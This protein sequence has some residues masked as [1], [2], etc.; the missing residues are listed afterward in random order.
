MSSLQA[1]YVS[2]ASPA[3]L[4]PALRKALS[5]LITA[6]VSA[7]YLFPFIRL[8]TW[9]PDEGISE[10]GA[11]VILRGGMPFRDFIELYPPGSYYWLALFFRLFGVTLFTARGLLLCEGVVTAVLV[12]FLSRRLGGTG[13]FATALLITTSIPIGVLNSPHY[14]ANLFALAAFALFIIAERRLSGLSS[15]RAPQNGRTYVLLFLASLLAGWTSCLL[16]EKGLYLA[17]AF[18]ISLLLLH[19]G[20]RF[21]L[22]AL[23]ALG[24][25]LPLV[26]EV[27]LFASRGAL[28]DLIYANVKLP[29]S[30][31]H[32]I[33]AVHYGYFLWEV[34][35]QQWFSGVQGHMPLPLAVV[36]V[37]A[38]SV[39]F[40]LIMLLPFAVPALGLAER[41][42]AFSRAWLPYWP[43][44]FAIFASELHRLDI[45]HL[46]NGCLLLAV[47]FFAL[48]EMHPKPFLRHLV[49]VVAF[50]T[51]LNGAVNL[52][53]AL[54]YKTVI[55]TRRGTLLAPERDTALEF[56]LSHTRPGDNVLV[57]PY[58]PVY[59][60]L[61]DLRN[62]TRLD[63]FIYDKY[64]EPLFREAVRDLDRKR[65]RYVLWDAVFSG[66]NLRSLFPSYRPPPPDQ[67][68]MEP[69][70][71]SHYH[72]IAFENGFRILE[73]NQ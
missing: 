4:A 11:E 57:Y 5:Y 45:G 63:C 55:H 47:L 21:C 15:G 8:F 72:Q 32:S 50:C 53:G 7:L 67:L 37:A 31:Y 27:G 24:Y 60:F 18:V 33:N 17:A 69:Y 56:L 26:A 9:A 59:Y 73:R 29:L 23:V 49:L 34:K 44:A 66:E 48:T 6:F 25:A 36:F 35:I 10:Y 14:D 52:A 20:K 46:R 22:A 12:F 38:L 13:L 2:A 68:I 71:E 3:A 54:S 41:A 19:P 1:N 43:A 42:R 64:V 62:P 65:V 16:Q 58:R 39:P 61:A 51:V 28:R 70:L 40:V 30:I